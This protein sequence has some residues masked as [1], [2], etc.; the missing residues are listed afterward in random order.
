M[1]LDIQSLKNQLAL[2]LLRDVKMPHGMLLSL[3]GVLAVYAAV[4]WVLLTYPKLSLHLAMCIPISKLSLL[5]MT[6]VVTH[7]LSDGLLN[8]YM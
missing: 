8:S 1:V 5:I 2:F 4:P 3:D 7:A 6:Q